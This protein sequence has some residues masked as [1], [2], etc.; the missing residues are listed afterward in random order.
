MGPAEHQPDPHQKLPQLSP[1]STSPQ[2]HLIKA[3]FLPPKYTWLVIFI[4]KWIDN[5][6]YPVADVFHNL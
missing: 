6:N 3:Q 1:A 5:F 4:D 2:R